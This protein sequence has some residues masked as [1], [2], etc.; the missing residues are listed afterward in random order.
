MILDLSTLVRDEFGANFDV[1]V[2]GSGPSGVALARRLAALG[3]NVALME[4]GGFD[5]D[6]QSQQLYEGQ[7][8]GQDY[9]P[10]DV[11][12]LRFFGGTSNHWGGMCRT[13]DPWDYRP[14]SY[15]RFS[16]WPISKRHLDPYRQ[17]ADAILELPSESEE[18]N[19][20]LSQ[21]LER[22]EQIQFRFS[23]HV[24]FGQKYR[25][26]IKASDR[27]T[28]VLNANLIDLRLTEDLRRVAG[29]VFRSYASDDPGLTVRAR[30]YV[31]CAGGIENPR[32]LLN[33]SSQAPMG[34]GNNN[35]LVG[36]FFNDH[37]TF[38]VGQ[39]LLR[40]P[41]VANVYFAPTLEFMRTREILNFGLRLVAIPSLHNAFIRSVACNRPF[42]ERLY[43]YLRER[44]LFCKGPALPEYFGLRDYVPVRIAQE[45]QLDPDSRVTL[46][47]AVDRFG[48][49]KAR[50]NWQ[51]SPLDFHTMRTA[52]YALAEHVAEQDIGRIR[53]KDWLVAEPPQLPRFGE[54][55]VGGP[56]HMCTTRMAENPREGVVNRDCRVHGIANFY[57]G[58]SSVYASGGHAN[59]TYTIV[60]LALR[61]G[62]H[63]SSQ[64]G[65]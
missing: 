56:H 31:L 29:A 61:L 8:V 53:I 50:L 27:I 19:V 36:R 23:P 30:V 51:V 65:T 54:D 60:Q 5:F 44:R 37:P 14:L 64:L 58:G 24:R 48:L 11:C 46:G 4:A 57:I 59:P 6:E 55:E 35:G 22:L 49:R 41:L 38:T 42:L 12:R 34:I 43:E 15:H 17:E 39:A 26:E 63:I 16:G 25:A 33:F 28:L 32:L 47:D 2:V 52:V 20:P 18:P 45:Q 13:L 40:E 1:C 62:D 7:L 3:I 21:E 10:L 9:Y